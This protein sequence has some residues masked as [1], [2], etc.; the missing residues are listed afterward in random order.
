MK[1]LIV[2]SGGREHAIAWKVSQN[3]KVTKI[4]A[5]P[6]NAYNKFLKNCENINISKTEEIL[7]FAK[8]EK[9]DLTIVGSEELLVDGIVDKFHS[10]GLKIFGPDKRAAMLEGSKAFAK[11]FMQKYGVKTAKYKAFT[12]KEEAIKYLDEMNYPLVIKASGLAAG[13]GVLICQN[14]KEAL[15]ALDEIMTNKIFANAGDTVVIEEFLDGVEVSIL[16]ITDSKV[17]LPFLSAKDHKKISEGEQG[18]NTGGM[19]VISPNPYYTKEVEEKFIKDILKPT[20][21]GI[22]EEKLDFCGIIFFGLMIARDEVYL[23]EYN[24]RMGDPETQAVLPLLE[25]DYLNLIQSAMDKNLENFDIKW[26][27]AA[28]CC[29]VLAAGGY[30]VKYEKGNEI[31]GLEEFENNKNANFFLAGV[32]SENNKFFTNGGRVLNIVSIQ[33]TAEKARENAYK[34][35]EKIKFKDKYFRK[36]IG[37]MRV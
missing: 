12:D 32:K 33:N 1:I 11:D 25:S 13:K 3:K 17:I 16:S 7:N 36:D 14:K 30:P 19:G 10:Q 8:Q 9:I 37:L 22:K 26:K 24:M 28:S 23:L 27:D 5:A 31:E 15:D 4:Y 35:L 2:G 34:E 6:G 29:V 18:L 20:L 21:K